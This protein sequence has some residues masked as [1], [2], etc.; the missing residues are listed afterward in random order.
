MIRRITIPLSLSSFSYHRD[1]S[2]HKQIA[3]TTMEGGTRVT[4]SWTH[5]FSRRIRVTFP[6]YYCIF[7][8]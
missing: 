3:T 8:F 7:I 4:V 1:F 5:H 2:H 6:L